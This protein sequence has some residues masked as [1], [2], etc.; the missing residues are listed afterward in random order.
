MSEAAFMSQWFCSV[1]PESEHFA[2]ITQGI[3][4]DSIADNQPA[5][6]THMAYIITHKNRITKLGEIY[7]C[8]T[9]EELEIN[10]K[11]T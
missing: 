11:M 5:R 8:I 7:K 10:K 6:Q 9:F 4:L 3:L 2:K 1:C